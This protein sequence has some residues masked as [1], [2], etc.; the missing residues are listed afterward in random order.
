M[1]KPTKSLLRCVLI[2]IHAYKVNLCI[3]LRHKKA[4]F[5]CM[6]ESILD[7]YVVTNGVISPGRGGGGS[8]SSFHEK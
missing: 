4:I 6:R 3:Q 5:I 1:I 2:K 8:P 7:I